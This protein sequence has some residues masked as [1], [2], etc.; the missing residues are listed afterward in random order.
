MTNGAHRIS[1]TDLMKSLNYLISSPDFKINAPAEDHR[2]VM[3]E[4]QNIRMLSSTSGAIRFTS[5]EQDD[6]VTALALAAWSARKF[7]APRQP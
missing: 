1:K 4:L 6:L 5:S 3:Q 7:L 2:A